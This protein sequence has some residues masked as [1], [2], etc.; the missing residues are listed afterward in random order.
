MALFVAGAWLGFLVASWLVAGATFRTA[1][2]V[3]GPRQR[4]EMAERLRPIPEPDRRV[5]LRH[6]SSEINRWMFRRWAVVQG[7]LAVVLATLA[8]PAG[9]VT[10]WLG[11]ATL[12]IVAVQVTALGPPIESIGRAHDFVP[13]P[14]PA[15]VGRRFGMLHGAFVVL[16]LVK[17]A[18]LV[19]LAVLIARR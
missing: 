15:E 12:L 2:D 8:W 10:R 3:L 9:G 6:L 19:A 1:E 4:P 14:L 16:D 5:A 7:V 18:G 13:R 17:A 11:V